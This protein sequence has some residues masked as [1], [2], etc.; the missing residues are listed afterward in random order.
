M[1]DSAGLGNSFMAPRV[2]F[3]AP[4]SRRTRRFLKQ[5]VGWTSHIWAGLAHESLC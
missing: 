2:L 4:M 3:S 5:A 1:A